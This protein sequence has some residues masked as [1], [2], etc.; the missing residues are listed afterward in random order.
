MYALGHIRDNFVYIMYAL[1]HNKE[2]YV[3][4][5][6]ALGHNRKHFVVYALGYT[7][8]QHCVD[9]LGIRTLHTGAVML[10]RA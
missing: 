6:Y 1:G 5:I 8:I 4:I 10:M 9:T 7:K 2:N 3:C